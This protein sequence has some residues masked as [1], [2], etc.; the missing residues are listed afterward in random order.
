MRSRNNQ[1]RTRLTAK[2]TRRSLAVHGDCGGSAC[3]GRSSA[4]FAVLATKLTSGMESP[5]VTSVSAFFGS[6]S[7]L[8]TSYL[9]PG[10]LSLERRSVWQ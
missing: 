6:L 3:A 1:A 10:K 7:G 8:K 4:N 5:F 2:S 9:Q